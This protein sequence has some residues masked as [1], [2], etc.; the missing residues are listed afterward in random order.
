MRNDDKSVN[1]EGPPAP[2]QKMPKPLKTLTGDIQRS[3]RFYFASVHSYE[4]AARSTKSFYQEAASS[5]DPTVTIVESDSGQDIILARHPTE[6]TNK[7]RRAY[8]EYLRELLLIRLMT[9]VEVFL[10]DLLVSARHLRYGAMRPAVEHPPRG[11]GDV[12]K[13]YKRTV[14]VDLSRITEWSTLWD[15]YRLRNLLVHRG[16]KTGGPGTG[17]PIKHSS[18]SER[19]LVAAFDLALRFGFRTAALLNESLPDIDWDERK[20][21]DF[22]IRLTNARPAAIRDFVPPNMLS[23][24]REHDQAQTVVRL[25]LLASK[26]ESDQLF[27]SLRSLA[28]AGAIRSFHRQRESPHRLAALTQEQKGLLKLIVPKLREDWPHNLH[29]EVA[30]KLEIS[31]TAAF[32]VLRQLEIE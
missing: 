19:Q 10:A 18:V 12:R 5:G 28:T 1:R 31:K 24:V 7:Y 9:S 30:D 17:I 27:E 22:H 26:S 8:P 29:H 16:G 4:G 15:L 11:L 23:L 2:D 14:A 6:L 3:R 25:S 32:G 13:I 21:W 20:D